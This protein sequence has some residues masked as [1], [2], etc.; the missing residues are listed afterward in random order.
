M[1]FVE[2]K[3]WLGMDVRP[4]FWPACVK[5]KTF[6]SPGRITYVYCKLMI[7]AI[8]LLARSKLNFG[9][10]TSAQVLVR[11]KNCEI[12]VITTCARTAFKGGKEKAST[13]T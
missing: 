3:D 4:F 1:Q 8:S 9:E 2:Q 7:D 12:C 13:H 5:C 6:S 11:K 10:M